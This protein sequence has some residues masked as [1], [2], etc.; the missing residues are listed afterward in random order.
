V[1]MLWAQTPVSARQPHSLP[2]RRLLSCE[3]A[4][5]LRHAANR[6][7]HRGSR[8]CC[9]MSAA[10][11]MTTV[12]LVGRGCLGTAIKERLEA[13]AHT[14]VREASRS[15][16]DIPLDITNFT[17]DASSSVYSLDTYLEAKSVDH[18]VLACPASLFGPLD[19]FTAASW[20]E[21]LSGKL[22]A[23]TQLVLVI[24]QELSF[25][26]DGGSIT[27][28]SGQAADVANKAWPGLAVN[29]AG[30]N[31]FVRNAG[32]DLPRGIRLNAVSPCL[33]TETAIKA[34]LPTDSTISAADA[35]AVYEGAMFS[36]DTAT[37]FLA[38]TQAVIEGN[39]SADVVKTSSLD[40]LK[41]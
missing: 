14:K 19:G 10:G 36:D 13:R 31:A 17:K 27:V 22:V 9:A 32:L 2:Q 28:S 16:Q 39:K 33:V 6:L 24:L 26:K 1:G 15:S 5:L 35:A 8:R 3:D 40:D 23:V 18:I 4:S 34:G 37:V 20:K 21:N 11:T 12:L 29:N 25:L 38:G 41:S 7:Q 30:I